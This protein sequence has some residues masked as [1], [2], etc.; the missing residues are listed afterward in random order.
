MSDCNSCHNRL[1]RSRR[2]D[3]RRAR[4]D[5]TIGRFAMRLKHATDANRVHLLCRNMFKRYGG[6]AAF[7]ESWAQQAQ[8]AM[9]ERPGSKPSLEFF[10]G[11]ANLLRFSEDGRPSASELD[12]KG[13]EDELAAL[14]TQRIQEEPA[15]AIEALQGLGWRVSRAEPSPAG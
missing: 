3:A 8:R 13:L 7:T 11:V 15:L 4:R 14:L 12:D 5:Q 9:Q 2:R 1:E 10:A 6:V